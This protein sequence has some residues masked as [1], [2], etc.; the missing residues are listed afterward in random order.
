MGQSA[1]KE[2]VYC[3]PIGE[4]GEKESAIYRCASHSGLIVCPK[5]GARTVQEMFLNNFKDIP[6]KDFIGRQVKDATGKAHYEY[7]TWSEIEKQVKS[8][9]TAIEKLNLAPEK[10]QYKDFKCRFIGIQGKNSVEWFITDITNIC[11]GYTTMPLYDTL[12]EEAVQHMFEETE[13]ETLFVSKDQI[14]TITKRFKEGKCPHLKN[15]IILDDKTLVEEDKKQLEGLK[16]YPFSELITNYQVEQKEYPKITPDDVAFFSY[17]SG[18]TGRPKGA[19]VTHRNCAAIVGGAEHTL[20]HLTKDTVHLSYLPLAHVFEKVVFLHLGYLGAKIAVYGG[21]V[22]KLK[23]DLELVKPTVFCSVPRLFNKFHDVISKKIKDQ[24]GV[25]GLLARQALSSKLSAAK[26][27]NYTDMIYDTLIFNKT[28]QTLGGNVEFCL[29]ASAPLSAKVKQLLKASFCCPVIEGYGQTEGMGGQFVQ[30]LNDAY[31]ESVGGPLPCNEFKLVDIPDMGYTHKDVDEQGRSTPRGEIW[32][33]GANIIPGYYKNDEK[34]LET[35]EDGWLKSGDIGMLVPGSNALKLID[36]KKN[37]FKLSHGEYV[38]P[39]KLEEVYK[40]T[41]GIA[42]IY[43]YGESVKSVLIAIVNL[44]EN[45]AIKIA[46]SNG[47]SGESFEEIA[48]K[49]EMVELFK[50]ELKKAADENGLKGFERIADLYIDP[51]PFADSDLITST[52]KLKR[53][54]AA[55]HY[56]VELAKLYEGKE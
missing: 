54:E 36:R 20:I 47:I 42:D 16:W 50:K 18:T 35:F 5:S 21:D 15:L 23:D 53:Q 27:G 31:L 3:Q 51:K 14:K 40:L 7:L 48:K 26:K 45:Q 11:Y 39:E 34:N 55:K 25:T 29:S 22:Q 4:A 10:K 38:A 37:L 52:F 8:L 32:M 24:S 44:D 33:R 49:P 12:G 56:K 13:M 30:D 6:N 17:T 19:I 28:K 41:P 1:S 2:L 43:V 46:S 9:G